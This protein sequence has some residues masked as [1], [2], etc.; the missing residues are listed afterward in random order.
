MYSYTTLDHDPRIAVVGYG[1]WG[2]QCHT[3]LINLTEG[4]EL[5]CVVSSDAEKRQQASRDRNCL[6]YSSFEEA[7]S[8]PLVDAVVL[9]TPSVTHVDLTVK[10]LESGKHVLTDKVMCLNAAEC[11]RMIAAAKANKKLLTVFQNRRF[12]GD[13]QTVKWLMS[14]GSLGQ[15]KWLEQSWIG[16]GKWGNWRGH[17]ALGGGRI[18]DLG[19]HL[20]DQALQLFPEPVESVYCRIHHD[21]EDADIESEA[22]IVIAFQGG[23]TAVTDLSSMSFCEKPR[24]LVKGDAGTYIKYGLDPQEAAMINGNIDAAMES[25]SKY[26]TLKGRNRMERIPTLPGNWRKFYENFRDSL[27]GE[28][29]PAVDLDSELRLMEVIDAIHESISTGQVVKFS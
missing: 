15:V 20:L 28:A 4:L 29:V 17:K 9:A 6:A 25:P 27:R 11:R 19:A 24:Y 1:R 12:D 13:F 16:F 2:R 10:A 21:W 22:L 18:Y 14:N 7:L 3:Y 26:G 5:R 8:D 23:K